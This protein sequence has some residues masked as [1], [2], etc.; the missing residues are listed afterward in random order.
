MDRNGDTKEA[1][2]E[3]GKRKKARYRQRVFDHYG[4]ICVRCGFDDPRALSIDHTNQDGHKHKRQNGKKYSGT[5]LHAW[6]VV[7]KF[8]AHFR[9]LCMNC[10]FI[11][12]AIA[13]AATKEI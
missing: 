1:M 7:N 4:R 13:R 10:Q 11:V 3:R 12:W 8:P 9:T 2:A 5:R 6:L